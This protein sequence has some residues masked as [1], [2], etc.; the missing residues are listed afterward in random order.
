MRKSALL[1]VV[2]YL[3]ICSV[4]GQT[5][6]PR[7]VINS[8]GHSAKVQ[9]LNF[10]PDGERIISVSEDKTVRVWNARNG[11]ML[12]KYESEIGDGSN[13]MLYASA[14]SPDGN[15]LAIAG[16][17][18]TKDNQV[19][20]VIIDLKKGV[21]VATAL[22][23][24]NVINSL[25]FTGNGK[26]LVS[27]S[28]DN[29]LKVWT[30]DGSSNY[31][32]ALSISTGFPVKYLSMN[33]VTMDVAVA[34]EGKTEILVYSLSALEKGVAKFNPR[35]WN[36]HRGRCRPAGNGWRWRW[37]KTRPLNLRRAGYRTDISR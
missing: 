22:G 28:D 12:K 18:I 16:Y 1:T 26:Y 21:Q 2:F 37:N 32:V 30:V 27:G 3:T 14:L 6:I 7:I 23:H 9:N 19:Y 25:A 13:G 11:E 4:N 15:L 36:R 35:F 17:T 20:I 31:K 33:P 24:T 29:S 10:T 8:M 34:C 5:G